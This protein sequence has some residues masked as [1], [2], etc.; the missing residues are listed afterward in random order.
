MARLPGESEKRLHDQIK[1]DREANRVAVLICEERGLDPYEVLLR[2]GG[3]ITTAHHRWED[4]R[5]DARKALAGWRAVQKY[6]L[7]ET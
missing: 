2:P 3:N 4:Y 7:T 5:E 1:F 6:I